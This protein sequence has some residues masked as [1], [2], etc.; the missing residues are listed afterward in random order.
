MP[1]TLLSLGACQEARPLYD[2]YVK[3]SPEKGELGDCV[4]ALVC[5]AERTCCALLTLALLQP[6]S[7][8]MML[9]MQEKGVPCMLCM[10]LA[11]AQA[12]TN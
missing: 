4:S 8:R 6:F 10:C 3:G 1:V 2:I 5:S 7:H 12:S 9:T 11:L